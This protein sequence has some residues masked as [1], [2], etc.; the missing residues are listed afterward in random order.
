MNQLTYNIA[1][2][3]QKELLRQAAAHRLARQ[4]AAAQHPLIPRAARSYGGA[5]WTVRGLVATLRARE[6]TPVNPRIGEQR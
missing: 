2:T 3:R 4:V 1:L 6:R 5:P